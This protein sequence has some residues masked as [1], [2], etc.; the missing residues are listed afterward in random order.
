MISSNLSLRLES[1][2]ECGGWTVDP[3]HA[4]I[5][6]VGY[7]NDDDDDDD[8]NDDD[9]TYEMLILE[10]MG[11]DSSSQIHFDYECFEQEIIGQVCSEAVLVRVEGAEYADCDG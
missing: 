11:F 7:E 6:S 5:C 8:N 2:K 3:N 1:L 9:L 4:A 10:S